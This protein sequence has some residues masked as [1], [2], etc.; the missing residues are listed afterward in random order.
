MATF[1]LLHHCG[2]LRLR[3]R[4]PKSVLRAILLY[5]TVAPGAMTRSLKPSFRFALKHIRMRTWTA[6]GVFDLVAGSIGAYREF[7]Q[8]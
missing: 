6:G 7:F 4:F 5:R 2:F 3:M 8:P 1:M